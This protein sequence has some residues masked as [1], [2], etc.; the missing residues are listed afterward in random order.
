MNPFL[1]LLSLVAGFVLSWYLIVRKVV[2]EAPAV[3]SGYSPDAVGGGLAYGPEAGV[4]P[5]YGPHAGAVGYGYGPD[6][7][8]EYGP[9]AAGAVLAD[10]DFGPASEETGPVGVVPPA[11]AVVPAA[12][13]DW[14]SRLEHAKDLL[15]G[16]AA[17]LQHDLSERI[18]SARTMLA[19]QPSEQQFTEVDA[20]ADSSAPTDLP[21]AAVA[22]SA[23]A[24]VG[25]RGSGATAY[26]PPAEEDT[27]TDAQEPADVADAAN[28]ASGV[29][30]PLA[31][32]QEPEPAAV[33]RRLS[34][35]AD[36]PADGGVPDG[37]A[38]KGD[39]KAKLYLLAD[40]P[41]FDR[42]R[43]DIWFLDEQAA[44]DEGYAHYI[45]RP[46]ATTPPSAPARAVQEPLLEA[47]DD[48]S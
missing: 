19:G 38:V 36:A 8:S 39:R 1:F 13:G 42:A 24:T 28:Q 11:D 29:A 2:R 9:D 23:A 3:G 14:A 46:R 30:G 48:E 37:Y 6:A 12:G 25:R 35:W 16:G 45:R 10:L 44:Q 33:P 7:S 41:D 5:D 22:A 31:S 17:R 20:A 40:D 32:E 27:E 43:P 47:S 34:P 26:R 21:G 18:D 4:G 15:I